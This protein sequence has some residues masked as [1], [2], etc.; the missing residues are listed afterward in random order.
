MPCRQ[1]AGLFLWTDASKGQGHHP[2]HS[3]IKEQRRIQRQREQN[4]SS[5]PRALECSA[6]RR[7]PPA[8]WRALPQR[9]SWGCQPPAGTTHPQGPALR[10]GGWRGNPPPRH[11]TFRG[12]SSTSATENA[13]A[14]SRGSPPGFIPWTLLLLGATTQVGSPWGSQLHHPSRQLLL[15]RGPGGSSGLQRRERQ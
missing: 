3:C 2:S 10:G 12:D 1:P 15:P 14:P 6:E 13:S 8:P 5:H 11:I 7:S 9:A 4:S